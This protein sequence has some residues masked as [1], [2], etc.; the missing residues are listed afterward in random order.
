MLPGGEFLRGVNTGQS[1]DKRYFALASNFEPVNPGLKAFA[2]D[3]LTDA[4]FK[5]DNDLV[6]PTAAVY[7]KNGSGFFPIE[8]KRVF[9]ADAGVS[10]TGFFADTSARGQ[11]LD[12]ER[13]SPPTYRITA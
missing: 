4:I 10:H 9:T 3:R 12:W 5:T 1:D 2:E 13:L 11:I 6:V 8:E 7:E